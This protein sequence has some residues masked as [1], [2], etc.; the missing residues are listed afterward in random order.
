MGILFEVEIKNNGSLKVNLSD[1]YETPFS[2]EYFLK[3]KSFKVC[4]TRIEVKS[5]VLVWSMVI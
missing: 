4:E 1:L 3:T 5:A 2:L